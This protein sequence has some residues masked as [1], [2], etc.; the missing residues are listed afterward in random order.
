ML[1]GWLG[2]VGWLARVVSLVG[3]ICRVG[4]SV[5]SIDR[6]WLDMVGCCMLHVEFCY[7]HCWFSEVEEEKVTRDADRRHTHRQPSKDPIVDDEDDRIGCSQSVNQSSNEAIGASELESR[8][9]HP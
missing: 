6:W 8:R 3:Y 1:L 9:R 5:G 4:R 7:H 2:W